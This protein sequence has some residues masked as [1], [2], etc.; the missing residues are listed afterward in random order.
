VRR[1]GPGGACAGTARVEPDDDD[2]AHQDVQH[3][4]HGD[5]RR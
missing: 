2:G 5:G 4:E 1:V 3:D